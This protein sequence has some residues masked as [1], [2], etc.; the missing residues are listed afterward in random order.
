MG[1]ERLTV[2]IG[3][4]RLMALIALL[5]GC[6]TTNG[7]TS[8]KDP[9]EGFN[10]GVYAFN[11][12]VDETLAKPIATGYKNLLP[13]PVDKGVTNF[14]SNLDDVVVLANDL[15]QFKFEQALSDGSRVVW[16]TTA[17]LI[18]FIDVATHMDLPKHTQDFGLTLAHWGVGPGPFLMLPVLG[19]S[20]V[21]D[22]VGL[23]PDWFL[24]DPINYSGSS[25]N[26]RLALLGI[27]FIDKRADLLGASTILETAA[28][29]E[30]SFLRDAYLQ[31]RRYLLYGGSP[32]EDEFDEEF[33][34]EEPGF[35]DEP[36]PDEEPAPS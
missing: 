32:P 16:N 1:S 15:L 12:T 19:P 21:R 2:R 17:G 22:T 6:A 30:Y 33:F 14:F 20:T 7:P 4:L 36:P 10:R 5:Q 18:G 24:F 3:V 9:W 35:E 11:K 31:R 25:F 8:D 26:Q 23:V 29:D 28:L 13:S 27:K 34:E